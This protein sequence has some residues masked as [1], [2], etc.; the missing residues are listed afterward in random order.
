MTTLS[1]NAQAV[2]NTITHSAGISCFMTGAEP[3]VFP[4]NSSQS[5]QMGTNM[6]ATSGFLAP[7]ETQNA[8]YKFTQT[9]TTTE[10]LPSQSGISINLPTTNG[11]VWVI[12]NDKTYSQ[13]YIGDPLPIQQPWI[14]D[15]IPN[16]GGIF[17]NPFVYTPP[18]FSP[19]PFPPIK[20]VPDLESLEEGTHD[21]PGGKII[22]KKIKITEEQ[23]E[24]A[25]KETLGPD[26]TTEEKAK[27]KEELEDIQASEER[28]I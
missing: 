1:T 15:T 8:D 26:V 12:P 11:Y 10:A 27:I 18:P 16:S 9:T 20:V 24:K 25:I 4:T 2:L 3:Q 28:E 21:I 7:A 13:P 19:Q 14:G 6:V 23:L 5:F 17:P 22:I